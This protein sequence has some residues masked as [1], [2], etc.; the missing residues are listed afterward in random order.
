M[1]AA[2]VDTVKAGGKGH[3]VDMVVESRMES[4]VDDWHEECGVFGIWGHP[5]AV[6]IT[7]YGLHALQHRGQES[8]G[9]VC[10][11]GNHFSFHRLPSQQMTTRLNRST[12][13]VHKQ[14]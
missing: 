7:Y 5:D 2:G 11:D 1:S 12:I 4:G 10:S 14:S 8:A 13:L 6:Q 9:I 3:G